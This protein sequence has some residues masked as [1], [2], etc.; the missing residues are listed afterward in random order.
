MILSLF[1]CCLNLTFC[2]NQNIDITIDIPKEIQNN[3]VVILSGIIS[4][5]SA[6][7]ISFYDF[8][9]FQSSY[10]G[11]INWNIKILKDK[12]EYFIPMTIAGKSIPPKVIKLKA[13]E[14]HLFE[15]PIS[16][17]ELSTDGF[18]PL[19]SIESGF[20]EVQ[21]IVSLKKPKNTTIKSKIVRC[22]LNVKE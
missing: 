14:K 19:D 10:K 11:D 13:G 20:Y 5:S 17:K 6:N 12:Q 7:D 22:Y 3:K 18:F 15:I 4:N 16:F 1:L 2:N 9:L 21:L 8:K